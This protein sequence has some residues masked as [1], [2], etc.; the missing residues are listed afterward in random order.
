LWEGPVS[1]RTVNKAAGWISA[2]GRPHLPWNPCS[3]VGEATHGAPLALSKGLGPP[4]GGGGVRGLGGPTGC[5]GAAR[6]PWEPSANCGGA[7]YRRAAAERRGPMGFPYGALECA[8][9][10]LNRN[11]EPKIRPNLS[12]LWRPAPCVKVGEGAKK[13]EGS[14]AEQPHTL[15]WASGALSPLWTSTW[16]QMGERGSRWSP[17]LEIVGCSH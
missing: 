11:H 6:G 16:P 15:W 8:V 1:P 3:L 5:L 13:E 14:G 4:E 7:G 12:T 2:A 9:C 10:W 17:T